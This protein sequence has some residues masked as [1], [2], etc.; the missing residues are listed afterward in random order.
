MISKVFPISRWLVVDDTAE[1]AEDIVLAIEGLGGKADTADSIKAAEKLLRKNIYDVCVVD[2][3]YKGTTKWGIDLLPDLRTTLPGLPVIMISNSDDL[4]LPAKVI[5]AGADM[6]CPKLKDS[7]SLTKVLGS[8]AL[9]ATIIRKLKVMEFDTRFSK[10]LFLVKQTTDAFEHSMRR[11]E[12]RLLICGASGT[13]KTLGSQFFAH[14]YLKQNYGSISRNIV[15][16]DCASKSDEVNSL[17]LF[18]EAAMTGNTLQLTLFERA[19]GGVLVLDNIHALSHENQNKLK[20]VF[21]SEYVTSVLGEGKLSI[22]LIK[23]VATYCTDYQK[24]IVPGFLEAYAHREI[25][26]PTISTLNNDLP[27][28]IQFIFDQISQSSEDLKVTSSSEVIDKILDLAANHTFPANFRTLH[29]I[30]ENALS[31]A[32]ADHRSQIYPSDV[33]IIGSMRSS[34]IQLHGLQGAAKS[35]GEVL[36]G[37]FGEAL[38]KF[39]SSGENFDEAKDILRKIMINVASKKY[40]GNKSKIASALGISRQ[41]LYDHE[42]SE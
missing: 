7:F 21:D 22:G 38:L 8:S 35:Y 32:L 41:S 37:R 11:K 12:E 24:K 23:F 19:V 40:G 6:F 34:Q 4:D 15:Y 30:I 28:A 3:F 39:I 27:K 18:G 9:Q 42:E 20:S 2:C 36:E 5:R 10:E 17:L 16:H 33:E 29:Q 1:D 26:L 25:D 13:G 31:R 14:Q